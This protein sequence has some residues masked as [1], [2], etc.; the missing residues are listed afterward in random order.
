LLCLEI[1][2]VYIVFVAPELTTRD[3]PSGHWEQEYSHGPLPFL[4]GVASFALLLAGTVGVV[5]M[6]WRRFKD[7][8]VKD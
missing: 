1:S 6:I 3:L 2:F 8:R 7:L 5:V 4:G